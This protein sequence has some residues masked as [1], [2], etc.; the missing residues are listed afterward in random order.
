MTD[1]PHDRSQRFFDAVL[2][3]LKAAGYA[4]YGSQQRLAD[5]TG[6]SPGTVSRLMRGK[7]IPDIQFFPALAE[8]SGIPAL[9]LFVLAGHLPDEA[10]ESQQTLSETNQSQVGS[11]KI[12]PEEAADRLGFRDDVRRNIF[13]GFIETLKNAPTA[14]DSRD[15][16]GG[17]TAQM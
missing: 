1:A 8:A 17:A 14:D 7:T 11:E 6:M 3:A 12:T 16:S 10:L 2:P 13:I 4:E 5:D 9:E 15:T